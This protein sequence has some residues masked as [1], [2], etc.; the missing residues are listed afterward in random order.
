MLVVKDLVVKYAPDLPPVLQ[1]ISFQLK[2]GE[3]VG[4]I[5]RTGMDIWVFGKAPY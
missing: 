5:G 1:G 3:R 2:A 4:L